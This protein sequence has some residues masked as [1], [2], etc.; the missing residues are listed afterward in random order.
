MFKFVL[1]QFRDASVWLEPLRRLG[2]IHVVAVSYI[3]ALL[4]SRAYV[5]SSRC[6]PLWEMLGSGML[7]ILLSLVLPR[8]SLGLIALVG[9][10]S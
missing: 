7:A 6:I 1:Y 10:R 9:W 2:C 4:A 8:V 5:L 3:V